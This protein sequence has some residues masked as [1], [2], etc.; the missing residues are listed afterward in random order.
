VQTDEVSSVSVL[1]LLRGGPF[2]SWLRGFLCT[3]LWVVWIRACIT[4]Q[5]VCCIVL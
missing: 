5:V 3:P 4:G 2:G 1:A